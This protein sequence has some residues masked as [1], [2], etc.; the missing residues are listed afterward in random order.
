MAINLLSWNC[1]GFRTHI[2]DIKNIINKYLPICIALQETYLTPEKDP[3]IKNYSIQRKDNIQNGRAVGGVA[4]LYSQRFSSRPLALDTTLQAVAIQI[5]IKMLLTICAIYIPPNLTINQNELN[6]L[7]C[8][9]PAPFII[10]GDLN[11]HSSLW[12]SRDTNVRGF[13]IEK[14]ISDHNLCLLNDSS[15]T[16]LHAA[17]RSFHTL[18]L[19]I[20]S[21]SI[22]A[23]WNFSVDE[24]LNN[25]DHFPII[26]S[27]SSN[28]LTIPKQPPHFI[29]ERA[30]WQVFK[31]LSELAPDIVHLGDI[32]AAVDAVSNCIIKAAEASIPKTSGK[33]KKLSKPWWNERCS[34][35]NKAQKKA[36]NRF[37]RYPTTINFIAFKHAKAVARRV[38]RQ[39]QRESFR[40]Y[41][42]SIKSNIT[43]KELWRKV[44]K[45]LG[46]ID[47][48]KSLSVLNCN[49]QIISRIKDIAN[50]LGKTFA[51]VSS[52]EFYPQ[53]FIVYKRQE[54]R[55][56][57]KF[58]SS[59]NDIYNT[60]FTIHELRDALNNSHPTSP[61]PD[62][63]H[64]NMLKN[65]SENS[66]CLIL[67][68]FNRI[69]NGKAFP[70]AW[71]KAIVVP[72]PKVGKDPQNSSNYR[73]IA[74]TSCL[75]KLMERMVNKR[76]V[77]ILEKKNMLSKFQSGFRYGRSTED[78]VF[79]LET[80]IRD[81][82]VTKK[83]LISIFFDMDKAYDRTWRHGILRDLF[84]IGLRG[85]LPI[86]I[87][88]FL[89]TRTFRVRVGDIFSDE[90]YQQEGVP[91]GSVMSVTLFIIKINDIIKQ[92]S[93]YVH[94]SLYVDDFQIHCAGTDMSFVVRQIQTA[95]TRISEW[96][97]TNGFV[98]SVN[99]T[100]CMHFC[101]RRGLHPDPE[102]LL[103]GN[104]IPVVSEEKFLGVLLD[105]KLT[106]KPHV[107]NL[108]KKCNKSLDL[109]KVLSSKSWGADYD[110]LLKI[111]RALV[112]SKL[113][114]CSIVYGS[115]AKTVL[116]SLDSVH[117]QGLRLIS[118]AFRTS[119]V[120]S[121]YVMTGELPLQLR[122]EKQCIKYYFK[123]KSNRRHPM[124][125]RILSPILGTLYA[126]KPSYIPPFGHRIKK[127]L[128]CHRIENI[129]PLPEEQPP[130][131]WSHFNIYTVDDLSNLSKQDTPHFVYLQLFYHHRQCYRDFKTAYTDGSKA[132]SHVGSAAVFNNLTK[133]ER[134]HSY[135]NVFTSE[136][137][138][139]FMVLGKISICNDKK[140]IIYTDSRS[141]LEALLHISR[142]SHPLVNKIF[143]L[144]ASLLGKGYN[145]S[146][147]W[148]PGHIGIVGNE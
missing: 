41:V 47:M 65:L 103:N 81:A 77:Y 19:A 80:A 89:L 87:K 54:E 39:S 28:N 73:P 111:Y 57:Y 145:I 137:Y 1:H 93:P 132:G 8:Q 110:T 26:L 60:D 16:Y 3:K 11:G 115:A 135:C 45:I 140:W 35:A 119:P 94:G 146:F 114:Y 106:F 7:V 88:N 6:T 134:L 61:G 92:L 72:I 104:V 38:R 29:Y 44:R 13:Q 67:A 10:M 125:D 142:R 101:R 33:I 64:S 76:L 75:C 15:H 143:N 136:I 12:G 48:G 117:H 62:G 82:F 100:K 49:G 139:I 37:R 59:S 2:D 129:V 124:Y 108:K 23:K 113:D 84:I 126:N 46:T 31:D 18:D 128:S 121:L 148:I 96:A 147:C 95:I 56:E 36:W 118:G 133:S 51:E 109:L 66:L 32:D 138:A 22:L 131:P 107:S 68:L 55:V 86:F 144:Y 50:V 27:H 9:L 141:C 5:D 130:P 98:F 116:Q 14:F 112:L 21:P 40:K 105:R 97:D 30:N 53:D 123:V 120:Q 25:S 102:I 91:Q 24:D 58:E 85:N 90:F 127:I 34:E 42:N 83:H 20:C 52:D 43:S 63:I 69:W 99:K 122:R 17:T 78:N 71:R 79:Q 74:L 4:L 70:T